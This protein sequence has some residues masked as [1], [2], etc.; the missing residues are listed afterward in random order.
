MGPGMHAAVLPNNATSATAAVAPVLPVCAC[1]RPWTTS[2]VLWRT[3]RSCAQS[4]WTPRSV[5]Q[6]PR[7]VATV[8]LRSFRLHWRCP[9]LQ[10]HRKGHKAVGNAEQM[11]Q[12]ADAFLYFFQA[13]TFLSCCRHCACPFASPVSSPAAFSAAFPGFFLL[14]CHYFTCCCCCPTGS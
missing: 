6:T 5:F 13:L 1:R 10:L 9:P 4:C 12:S 11:N 7:G 3:Q 14:F 8:Q 2:G